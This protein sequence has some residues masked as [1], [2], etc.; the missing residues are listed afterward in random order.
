MACPLRRTV[1]L[2]LPV[3][4]HLGCCV[5]QKPATPLTLTHAHAV[6]GACTFT[7]IIGQS[8]T[9]MY[10]TII[11]STLPFSPFSKCTS[12]GSSFLTYTCEPH[13]FPGDREISELGVNTTTNTPTCT[14]QY[15]NV[16]IICHK[17]RKYWWPQQVNFY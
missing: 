3:A 17:N 6:A 1:R 11:T 15:N 14:S 5:L 7:E 4:G 2:Q 10:H 16:S 9:C 12:T 13:V 8:T